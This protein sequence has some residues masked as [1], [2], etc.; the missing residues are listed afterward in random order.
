MTKPYVK[1]QEPGGAHESVVAGWPD[2]FLAWLIDFIV[3]SGVVYV[4]VDVLLLEVMNVEFVKVWL[5]RPDM[6]TV[7]SFTGFNFRSLA[8]F[9]YWVYL[10]WAEAKSL[11]RAVLKLKVTSGDGSKITLRS[12]AIESFGK[13]F[14]LP[15]DFLVGYVAF[16]QNKQRLFSKLAGVLVV[17][18]PSP[19]ERK[20]ELS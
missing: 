7:Q 11:G 19:F 20:T 8:F 12:A 18:Y 16:Y 6:I 15:I 1:L 13:S 14:L 10:D 2:R 3:V 5:L 4:F 9:C 17:K